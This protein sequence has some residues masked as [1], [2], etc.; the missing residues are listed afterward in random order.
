M[1]NN[2]FDVDY[3]LFKIEKSLKEER[4]KKTLNII[5]SVIS[6][7]IYI[8]MAIVTFVFTFA[9]CFVLLKHDYTQLALYLLCIGFLNTS[10]WIISYTLLFKKSE[11]VFED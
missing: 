10:M 6:M 9:S 7:F 11:K 1:K 5:G 3:E 8:Y 4:R 2:V